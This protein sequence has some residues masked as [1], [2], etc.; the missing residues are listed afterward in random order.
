MS[1]ALIKDNAIATDALFRALASEARLASYRD[2]V[3]G[4]WTVFRPFADPSFATDIVHQFHPRFW[5]MYLAC[6]L[7]DLGF[8][9]MP[10]STL[11]GP[12]LGV[13]LSGRRLWIEA[14]APGHGEGPDAVPELVEHDMFVPLPEAQV[15]LRFTAAILEK[16]WKFEQYLAAGLVASEDVCV[17][18]VSGGA[19]WNGLYDDPMPLIVRSLFPVGDLQVVLAPDGTK[20]SEGFA[21]RRNVPKKSGAFVPTEGFMDGS[22]QAL[23]GVLFSNSNLGNRPSVPGPD[24]IFIHNPTSTGAL[25]LGWLRSG[26]E[27]WVADDQL[28]TRRLS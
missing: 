14:A 28:M 19:I 27:F 22:L 5:E 24:F 16:A 17:A 21:M 18:A 2:Y 10:R 20:V 9:L 11:A 25:P 7:I 12:D 6:A 4:L 13:H 23:A 1:D 8:S 26:K 15:I 3:E